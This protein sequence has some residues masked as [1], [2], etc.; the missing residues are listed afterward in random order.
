MTLGQLRKVTGHLKT[1]IAN[2]L[3]AWGWVNCQISIYL[4]THVV[5]LPGKSHPQRTLSNRVALATSVQCHRAELPE[6]I[7][8]NDNV[9]HRRP[10]YFSSPHRAGSMVETTG[11]ELEH[12]T[13]GG[14]FIREGDT[15]SRVIRIKEMQIMY[16]KKK[17]LKQFYLRTGPTQTHTHAPQKKWT[18]M[19]FI[20]SA[21]RGG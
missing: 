8:P 19:V 17:T 6:S 1:V 5:K 2:S 14:L 13:I 7:G 3:A 20:W 11:N 12:L 4:S 21:R 18:S 16:N 10:H 15:E 9:R